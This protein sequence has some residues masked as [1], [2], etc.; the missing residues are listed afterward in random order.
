MSVT[1]VLDI[2]NKNMVMY[3]IWG[4]VQYVYTQQLDTSTYML[5]SRYLEN[6]GY[7]GLF[8]VVTETKV[9]DDS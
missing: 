9:L 6:N 3:N 4:F 2:I 7:Y 1:T 8:T 5:L